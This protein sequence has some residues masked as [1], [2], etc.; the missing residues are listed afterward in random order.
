MSNKGFDLGNVRQSINRVMEDALSFAGGNFSLPLDIYET[1]EHVVILT[2][3]LV[4]IIPEKIDVS[5]QDNELTISGETAPD[6][7][8]PAEA[9]LR[10]ERRYGRFSRRVQIGRKVDPDA[11]RAELKDGV[12]KISFPKIKDPTSQPK[13][14]PVIQDNE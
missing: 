7:S 2:A 3:P 8:I 9:Y 11:A 12:L 10:R 4:G 1:N 6:S 14:I 5:V 13:V